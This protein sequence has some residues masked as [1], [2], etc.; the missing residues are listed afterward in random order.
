MIVIP[1]VKES[2][3]MNSLAGK[4]DDIMWHQSQLSNDKY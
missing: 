1:W 2:N 4:I 3:H